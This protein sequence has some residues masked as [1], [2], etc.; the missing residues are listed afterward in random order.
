[1][2]IL[3]VS[4]IYSIH[5]YMATMVKGFIPYGTKFCCQSIRNPRTKFW[6]ACTRCAYVS[7]INS[8]LH[9]HN[10]QPSYQ[11]LKTMVMSCVDQKRIF[12]ARNERIE[13]GAPAKGKGKSVSD[14]RKQGECSPWKAKGRRTKGDACSFRHDE[15]KSGKSTRSSTLLSREDLNSAELETFEY[16]ET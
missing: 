14:E 4:P 2:A 12:E 7:L 9:W 13:T 1:M 15:N 3:S 6:K 10:S 5:L 16:Q 11:K 8:K